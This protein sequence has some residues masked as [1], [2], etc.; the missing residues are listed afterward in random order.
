MLEILEINK[1]P[2]VCLLVGLSLL[3]CASLTEDSY[4][5]VQSS[6]LGIITILLD[7]LEVSQLRLSMCYTHT[8]THTHTPI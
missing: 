8:H 3:V 7:T 6:L 1:Q 2:L 4:G 5:V